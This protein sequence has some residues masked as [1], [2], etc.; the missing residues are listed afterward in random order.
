LRSLDFHSAALNT[1][2]KEN[3]LLNFWSALELLAPRN[4]G[5]SIIKD[6]LRVYV[7][8]ITYKYT[9]KIFENLE[10]SIRGCSVPALMEIIESIP[11]GSNAIEKC[12]ALVSLKENEDNLKKAFGMLDKNP[13]LRYRLYWLYQ[14]SSNPESILHAL[15]RHERRVGWQLE[16]IYRARNMIVHSGEN[17]PKIESLIENIHSYFDAALNVLY[18]TSFEN[19]YFSELAEMFLHIEI[20]VE[21]HKEILRR[22]KGDCVVDNYLHLIFGE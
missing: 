13:L 12:A 11:Q 7:P 16:R 1:T 18:S 21:R 19:R 17:P 10:K 15:Q 22:S 3:Q 8:V 6:V 5:S 2:T 9:Y 20:S 14:N 4:E